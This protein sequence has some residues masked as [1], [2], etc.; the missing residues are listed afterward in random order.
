MR[1][2]HQIVAG[3]VRGDAISNEARALR[4][5][6]RGWGLA[7]E[8]YCEGRRIF[9]GHRNEIRD[10]SGLAAEVGPEE[11][12]LLHLSVG[13]PANLL[14]PNLRAKKAILYHNI[15]PPGYFRGIREETARALALG[16][17][18]MRALAGAA[19]INLADSAFNAEE[20]REA[21]YRDP[22]VFP[23]VFDFSALGRPAAPRPATVLCKAPIT[24]LFVGRGAPN[25]RMEDLLAAHY[26][27]R[28]YADPEAKLIHIGSYSGTERYRALIEARLRE[29]QLGGVEIAGSV[30]QSVLNRAYADATVFLCMSEHE[31]F[32]APL[33]EAMYH[34]VPVVAFSA[35]A[36]P[37]TLAGAGVLVKEK[38][39][40]IIAETVRRI[41]RDSSLRAAILRGQQ[42]RLDQFCRR[43][44]ADELRI[45]LA[46]MFS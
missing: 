13:S 28:K 23:L 3:F 39:F 40:D 16:R 34:Q 33:I 19:E 18:Q 2:L 46:P 44:P 29:L 17:D 42:A 27:I 22:R 37:E 15:T 32:C 10:L 8:I 31:G 45:L 24:T 38:R 43:I 41:A 14:F 35:A 26:Y 20:M 6:F 1:A 36:V 25:K 30:S 9:A 5:I 4:D 12:V 7:S 11:G 21:G